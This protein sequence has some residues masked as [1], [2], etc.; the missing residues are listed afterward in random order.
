M[1]IGT[2]GLPLLLTSAWSAIPAGL[3]VLLLVARTRLEDA[4]LERE[5][6]G[7][8]AYQQATR[9]RLVPGVW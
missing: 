3:H 4:A 2:V 1:I 7:Y 9:F 5:L 8:R 6:D